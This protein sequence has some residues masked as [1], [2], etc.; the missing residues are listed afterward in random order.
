MDFAA[1]ASLP[2][3][4][5]DVLT[6]ALLIA[7][8]EHAG[9][10]LARERA[11]VDEIAMP[12]GRLDGLP[13]EVQA[14]RLAEHLFDK[15]GFRGNTDEYYDPRNSLINDV[16]DR[17]LG[18]P[19]TLSILYVEVAR[20]AGVVA[21]GVSFPRHFLARIEGDSGDPVIVDPFEGGR[22]V[23]RH[24]LESMLPEGVRLDRAIISAAGPR[25]ILQRILANLKGIYATRGDLARLMVV[26]SR[27]LELDPALV[28]DRRDRGLIA[29]RLGSRE[30][31]ESDLE[32][33]LELAPEAGDAADVRRMLVRIKSRP[34]SAN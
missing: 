2:D 13:A 16:V 27:L 28:D 34:S 7:K 24:T 12:L 23:G 14:L 31:A 10:D 4:R 11:R 20:R 25:A 17:R 22:I 29:M 3:E 21:S 26:L 9:L 33:Y 19:I 18:I 8:D 30:V 1:F 32:K 15:L 6:G 5:M